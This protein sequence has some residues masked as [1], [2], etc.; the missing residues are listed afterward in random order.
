MVQNEIDLIKPAIKAEAVATASMLTNVDIENL[1]KPV[2]DIAA[3]GVLRPV[4]AREG[5]TLKK[6]VSSARAIKKG[7]ISDA[8][9]STKADCYQPFGSMP[10]LSSSRLNKRLIQ[11][12]RLSSPSSCIA[13]DSR[14]YSSASKRSWTANRSFLLS[15]VDILNH[16][17]VYS[18]QV[19][20]VYQRQQKQNPVSA[21]TPTGLLTTTDR[22][23]IELAVMNIITHP[24]GRKAHTLKSGSVPDSFIWLIAAVTRNCQHITAKIHHIEARS[25]RE[26]RQTLAREH[27]TFFAGRIRTRDAHT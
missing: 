1:K 7:S 21:D 5:L 26:A 23:V 14:S 3:P 22:E 12:D 15:L 20:N 2:F 25:E 13:I 19:D 16:Q 8:T 27:V 10:R 17:C 18:F 4:S 6:M 11:P 9:L 24:Q